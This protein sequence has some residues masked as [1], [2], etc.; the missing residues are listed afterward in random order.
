[1]DTRLIALAIPLFFLMIGI[2]V[3]IARQRGVRLYR[4]HDSI[5]SLACGIGEQVVVI[6][7]LAL[8][9]GTYAWASSHLALVH[10]PTT[11]VLGWVAVFFL[12]DHSFYWFHRAAHRVNFMWA[13][14]AVHHQSEEYNLSTALRQS[15]IENLLAWPFYLPLALLGFPIAM[16]ATAS[17]LNTLY[18]FWVHT[19]LVKTLGRA[20]GVLNTPASH[21][22]HHGID[23]EYVDKNYGGMFMVWDRLYRT[24]EPEAHEPHYG[25]VKPL[26]SWSPLWANLHG[27]VRMW[28]MARSTSGFGDK[29]RVFIAPPEWQ[30]ADLGGRVTVP[31]V[32]AAA[33]KR[34]ESETPRPI[35][36]YVL[37]QFV[38]IAAGVSSLMWFAAT[39][40]T[41]I[42]AA[43]VLWVLMAIIAWGGLFEGKRWAVALD[44]ARHAFGALVGMLLMA[45]GYGHGPS[46]AAR[47]VAVVSIG[48]LLWATRARKG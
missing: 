29:L 8:S 27:W 26:E 19:R 30:P 46:I 43:S 12:V 2:E 18:Q 1:M 11:S 47:A 16:Y 17:T 21:R 48:W 25:T 15:W 41:G 5:A 45:A 22:V 38:V 34:Y 33:Y 40:P 20:E 24:Y 10:I 13:G 23:P 6:F 36:V 39:L 9:L 31:V 3:V 35:D 32:D 37:G 7:T 14:H 42:R 4:L 28:T 44:I